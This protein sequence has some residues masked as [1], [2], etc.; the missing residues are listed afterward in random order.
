MNPCILCC[1]ILTPSWTIYDSSG[2]RNQECGSNGLDLIVVVDLAK[3]II[4]KLKPCNM[5]VTC[6]LERAFLWKF[7]PK[8]TTTKDGKKKGNSQNDI[9]KNLVKY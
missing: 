2:S 4:Y 7:A 3:I 1:N 9:N 6:P 5:R 8:N